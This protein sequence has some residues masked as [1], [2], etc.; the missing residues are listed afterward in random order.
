M[1]VNPMTAPRKP[2]RFGAE[3]GATAV[4][5]AIML[6][7]FLTLVVGII[8]FAFVYWIS[9]SMLLAA[10]A[11][12]RY[13]MVNNATASNFAGCTASPATLT[14]CTVN[15]AQQNLVALDATQFTVTATEQTTV[16]PQTMT[17]QVHYTVS[18]LGMTVPL[19]RQVTVP[20]I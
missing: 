17:I 16:T 10:E 12:G 19:T 20:L 11:A 7:I 6:S 2:Q 4:E 1:A 15:A 9:N 14:S 5:A 18:V 8:E 13:A 3:E